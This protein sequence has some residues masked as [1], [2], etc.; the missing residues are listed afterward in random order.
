MEIWLQR[1]VLPFS[2]EIEFNEPLCK[3][4]AGEKTHI[5]NIEWITSKDLRNAV[6]P[7]SIVDGNELKRM[8]AVISP[9]EVELF[10]STFNY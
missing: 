1:V 10:N 9:K 5:W 6:D 4:V 8:S 3:L 2:D 7:R